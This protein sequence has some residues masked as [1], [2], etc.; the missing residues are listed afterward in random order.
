MSGLVVQRVA[1]H[2]QRKQFL[3]FPW[4][5]YRNDPNWIPPLRITQKE[6]VGYVPHPFYE[7]NLVQTFLATRNGEVCGRIAAILNWG[8]NER[9]R[10]RRGFFGFFECVDDQEAADGLLDAVRQWFADQGISCLR[11]PTNPS[12]NYEL[13]TLIDGFDSP[14]TFMMTYNPP[15][16]ARLLENYGFRKTQDL[17]AFWGHIDM[18]PKIKAKLGPVAEQIIQRYNVRLRSMDASRFL[19]EVRMFLSVYNRSLVNT[20]GFVPMSPGEVDHMAAGLR[21]LIV[22]ELAMITEVDGRVVGAMF[23]LPDYNPR[24]RQIDGRL[25]PTGL[26]RLLLHKDR[27]QRIRLI[28]TN[29]IPEYQRLG[30]GLVLMS[31]IVP[32][33]L[34]SGVQEAEFSWVLES[35][36]LSRGALQKGGAKLT[37]TYRVYDLDAP[38]DG[39]VWQP[40]TASLVR[41]AAAAARQPLEIRPVQTRRDLR[42]FIQVPQRIYADDP[43]WVPPLAMEV[44][45]F[46]DRRKHPFYLHGEA[47]EFLALRGGVPMGRILVSD[48]SRYNQQH[49]SNVGCFGMFECAD[50]PEMAHA[51]LDAAAGWL[52]SRG[53]TSVMGPIDYSV[54]YPCG[55]LVDGFDS[56]PRIMNNHN[57][58]Y[59]AGL[60]ESW[61]LRKAKDLYCWWFIDVHNLLQR[62]RRFAER[63]GRR[64][65]VVVR[66]FRASDF[67]AEVARCREIYNHSMERNWGFVALSDAEFQYFAKR[68]QRLTTAELVLLAEVDGQPAG[69]SITVPDLNEAIRP[70]GGRLTN[71]G[72]PINLFRLMRRMRRIKTARMIVLDVLEA[73][74]R[75]GVAESLILRTLEHGKNVIGFTGAELGW[76]LEDNDPVNRTIEAVGAQ[77]YKTYRIYAKELD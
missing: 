37:K 9:Y 76:T 72:L 5:L 70:L 10:E 47:A 22:P 35:N 11:G 1:T 74:R 71:Y 77:R 54:N 60:L 12:L 25:F 58:R 42:Q 3:E 39:A 31:G 73:Y 36:S 45:E 26:F 6:L 16:Y 57:R 38:A 50:D 18:L 4:T 28:S 30:L 15:Y 69:F 33:V 52:R 19:E 63:L 53:R 34:A 66:P 43:H 27:I 51:L 2:R 32:K 13:G 61:G 48:D 67:E 65:H 75:R 24:I 23:G 62:W 44:K 29:V 14:P 8:H 17:Y 21:H 64:G 68:L 49:A 20:W 7:R 40:K 56:P 41:P 46:L 59:Y 55:L